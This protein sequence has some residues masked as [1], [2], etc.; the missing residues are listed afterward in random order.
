MLTTFLSLD[1]FAPMIEYYYSYC[2]CVVK[3]ESFQ[4]A[5]RIN[6][7][8]GISHFSMGSFGTPKCK[9]KIETCDLLLQLTIPNDH[10]YL[11][12][13]QQYTKD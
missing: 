5:G 2:N 4:K 11:Q 10:T 12:H 1:R 13:I 8:E 9:L 3:G 6:S 7:H